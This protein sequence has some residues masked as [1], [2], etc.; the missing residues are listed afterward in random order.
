MPMRIRYL[1]GVL[2]LSLFALAFVSLRSRNAVPD[3]SWSEGNTLKLTL[4][5]LERPTNDLSK[6]KLKLTAVNTSDEPIVLDTEC[7]CG[8]SLQF[9]SDGAEAATSERT[10]SIQELRR[11]PKSNADDARKRFVALAPGMSLS[12]S[13]DLDKPFPY[14]TEGHSTNESRQHAGF[15]YEA[16]GRFH[17]PPAVAKLSICVRYERGVHRMAIRDF[18]KWYGLN[19]GEIAFWQGRAKSNTVVVSKSGS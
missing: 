16:E 2:L 17:F 19:R 5:L 13:W 8:F 7:S 18:E 4:V 14:I 10:V 9:E 6:T 1:L 3:G 11:L 15:Y 12:R